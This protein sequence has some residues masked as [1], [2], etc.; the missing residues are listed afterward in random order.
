MSGRWRLWAV[1]GALAFLHFLLHVGLGLG[2]W[3]P[4]LLTVALLVGARETHM[5]VG[6][7]L[8]FAF[9]LM[10]DAFSL[11]SFG[12]NTVALTVVGILGARTRDLFVGDSLLFLAFYLLVGKWLRDA[13]HW[14]MAGEGVRGPVVDQLLVQSPMQSL[15][16]AAVGI[17][18]LGVTGVWTGTAR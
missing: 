15:Y 1:V 2:G 13:V 11:L 9:G 4:D 6:A 5:G 7:G 8:G 16:A 3:V 14:I 17:V 10:E 12:A 18:V